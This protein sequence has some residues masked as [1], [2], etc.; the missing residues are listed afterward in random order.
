HERK[1][2]AVAL[3]ELGY[4]P[5][6]F[7]AADHG[8]AGANVAKLAAHG[9]LPLDDDDRVHSL[10]GD[11]D[12][13][14]SVSHQGPLIRRRVEVVGHAAVAVRAD[15]ERVLLASEPAAERH[16][17]LEQLLERAFLRGRHAHRDG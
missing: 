12:P 2:E 13:A 7:D 17:L 14:I 16:Q 1:A 5:D 8:V 15:D 3:A 11:L 10:I 6:A 4:D 9:A